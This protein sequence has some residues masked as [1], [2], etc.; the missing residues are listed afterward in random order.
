MIRN[1]SELAQLGEFGLIKKIREQV[2]KFQSGAVVGIGDDA[3]GVKVKPGKI[4]L[5]TTDTLVENVHFKWDY[6]SGYQVGWKA[7]AVNLSDIAA[8]GG[9]PTYCLVTLGMSKEVDLSLID[10]IY[11]GLR[12]LASLYNIGIIGGDIVSSPIFFITVALL[13]EENKEEVLLRSEAK[14]GDFIYLTGDLGTSAAGLFCLKEKELNVP[15]PLREKLQRRHLLP[16]PRVN[17][18]RKIAKSKVA[19]SMID[20]SDGLTLD[21]SHILE[22][23]RV[24]AKIWEEKIPILK[25]VKKLAKE[26]NRSFL[27]WGLYGGEDYELLFTCSSKISLED[28]KN[29]LGFSVTKIGKIVKGSPE[30]VL[31]SSAGKQ[32]K[33]KPKGWD[34]FSI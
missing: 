26:F 31:I 2:K 4:A 7:L 1:N 34:H 33:L 20:V 8:M 16:S 5:F 32:R 28:I 14:E 29:S 24:G 30:I 12:A 21:L 11:Q 6:A 15:I 27:D 17:E 9:V 23:S 22:E 13:G 3:A 10:S 19:S 25:E 18:G